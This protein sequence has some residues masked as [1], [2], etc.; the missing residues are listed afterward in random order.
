MAEETDLEKYVAILLF[1]L[2]YHVLKPPLAR[3]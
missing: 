3:S 1:M 2:S